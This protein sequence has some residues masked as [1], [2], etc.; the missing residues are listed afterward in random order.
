M[1]R[2]SALFVAATGQNVGKTTLCLGLVSGLLK[3][4]ASVGYFKPVGQEHIT[5]E[6]GPVDKDVLLF[7]SY[8]RLSDTPQT[9]SPVLFPK[10]FTREFL[11]GKLSREKMAQSIDDAFHAI[12]QKHPITVVEGTGHTGVGSIID[13]NNAQVAAQLK[14]PLFLV[15]PG[16]VGSSFDE[17]ALNRTQCEK[18]G[19]PIGGIFLNQVLDDKRD[20]V[21]EYMGKALQRWDVPL[22]GCIPYDPFLSTSTMGDFEQLFETSLMTGFEFRWRHF[23]QIR[24]VATSVELYRDWIFPRQLVITPSGREDIVLATLAR[25]WDIKIANRNDDLEAGLILTGQ[26]PPK[27]SLVEQI[28]KA[29]IPMLFAPVSSSTAMKMI[30]SHTAKIRREDT[31]KIEEAVRVVEAHLDF[32]RI[33]DSISL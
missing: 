12:T 29:N 5:I 6:K 15:A 33:L 20:M 21:M 4:F 23:E 26:T 31:A 8:F 16:G 10:G 19:V 25:H 7:H 9:M 32:D 14:I 1:K 30:H 27:P 3:R 11:D 13:L 18:Y 22:L 17:L 2:S 24:L 28:R